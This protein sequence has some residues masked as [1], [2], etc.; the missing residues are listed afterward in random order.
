M[1]L[2]TKNGTTTSSYRKII[3]LDKYETGETVETLFELLE[4]DKYQH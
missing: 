1:K 4:Y 2:I 3:A